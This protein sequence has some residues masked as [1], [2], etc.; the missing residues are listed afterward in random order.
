MGGPGYYPGQ[1]TPDFSPDAQQAQQMT[2]LRAGGS[3]LEQAGQGYVQDVL[4]G[5]YLNANPYLDQTY[6]MASRAV[7]RSFTD[8]ALPALN[9]AFAGAGGAGSQLHQQYG[10]NLADDLGRNLGELATRIYGGD[11]AAERARQQQAAGMVPGMAGLDYRNIG[12]LAQMG[13][14]QD[15]RERERIAAEMARYQYQQQQPYANLDW[16]M[17]NVGQQYGQEQTTTGTTAGGGGLSGGLGGAM[18]GAKVGMQFGGPWGAAAGGI[19]GGLS[20]LFG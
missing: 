5:S 17:G 2:R 20:G 11:Y 7:T 9:A 16:Y 19:I 15:A 18:S 8:Q 1:L 14:L 13:E 12:Q 10:Q 4:G 3:P 6:D